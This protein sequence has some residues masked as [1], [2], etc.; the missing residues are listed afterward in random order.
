MPHPHRLTFF[1]VPLALAAMLVAILPAQA[2]TLASQGVPSHF[3]APDAASRV[4]P[5]HSA[6]GV[7]GKPASV[8]L[9]KRPHATAVREPGVQRPPAAHH[10]A[11]PVKPRGKL[12]HVK[13]PSAAP[14]KSGV[15]KSGISSS[16]ASNSTISRVA[17]TAALI[18]SGSYGTIQAAVDA[19]Q[20]GDTVSVPAGTYTENLVIDKPL[21]LEGVGPTTIIEPA[22]SAPTCLSGD[23]GSLC[24]DASNAIHASNV[25]LVQAAIVTIHD[26]TIDG[27]NPNLISSVEAGGSPR[28]AAGGAFGESGAPLN[29]VPEA[30]RGADFLFPRREGAGV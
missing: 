5:P 15:S 23:S 7:A 24:T 28:D 3:S 12:L 14:A 16:T 4:H 25:I 13:S 27:D 26:L 10:A 2:S 30:E 22:L 9:P 21:T 1:L 8:K 11:A 18:D 20:P 19:A 6:T 17:G 29:P